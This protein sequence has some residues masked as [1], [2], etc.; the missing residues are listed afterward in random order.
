MQL[1]LP[2]SDTFSRSRQPVLQARMVKASRLIREQATLFKLMACR[3]HNQ[4]A[5]RSKG[6]LSE[7]QK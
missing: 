3:L 7:W 2:I 5:G 1:E 6:R 4:A